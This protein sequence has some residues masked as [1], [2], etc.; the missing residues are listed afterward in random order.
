MLTYIPPDLLKGCNPTEIKALYMLVNLCQY[1][2]K[3]SNSGAQYWNS[4]QAWIAARLGV[5]R[6]WVSTCILRLHRKLLLTRIH[7]RRIHGQWKTNLYKIGP[8]IIKIFKGAR[9]GAAALVSHVKHS[10]H[11]AL[12]TVSKKNLKTL[13]GALRAPLMDPD[14][15]AKEYLE[16]LKT[17][18]AEETP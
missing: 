12:K 4:G 7:R 15:S 9:E 18:Y 10:L 17:K 8:Q 6:P 1:H 13:E 16:L 5:S 11:I 3:K 14:R 2:G